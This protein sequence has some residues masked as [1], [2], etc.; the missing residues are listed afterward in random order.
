MGS[1]SAPERPPSCPHGPSQRPISSRGR[2]A[3]RG[4]GLGAAEPRIAW[5]IMSV[6]YINIEAVCVHP[7]YICTSGRVGAG[8][9]L[10]PGAAAQGARGGGPAGGGVEDG[11][12]AA[13]GTDNVGHETRAVTADVAEHGALS[14]DVGE[15][16][17]HPTPARTWQ[18]AV[19]AACAVSPGGGRRRRRRVGGRQWRMRDPCRVRDSLEG[20]P[21]AQ[22]QSFGQQ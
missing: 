22:R 17:L 21:L 18:R 9:S 3:S 14:V 10:V 15:L 6:R 19:G 12:A 5:S 7:M 20:F 4:R 1:K 2:R 8:P 13:A 16:L 11:D